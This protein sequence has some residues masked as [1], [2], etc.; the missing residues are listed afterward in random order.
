MPTYTLDQQR[1]EHRIRLDC[2]CVLHDSG[3]L[4]EVCPRDVQRIDQDRIIALM[5]K[6]NEKIALAIDIMGQIPRG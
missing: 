4:L 5:L 1:T 6:A 3:L 2:G